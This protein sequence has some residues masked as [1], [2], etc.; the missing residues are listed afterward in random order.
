VRETRLEKLIA[1]CKKEVELRNSEKL[2]DTF[3]SHRILKLSDG[4]KVDLSKI[5]RKM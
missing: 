4:R 3:D 2:Q 5:E 1:N